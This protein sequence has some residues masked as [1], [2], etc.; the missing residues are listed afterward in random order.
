MN[1]RYMLALKKIK[2]EKN[3]SLYYSCVNFWV[4]AR[5]RKPTT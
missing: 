4:D 5:R 3:T 2:T 1:I